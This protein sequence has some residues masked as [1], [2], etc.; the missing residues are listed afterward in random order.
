MP[1]PH[2]QSSPQED[3][4]AVMGRFHAWDAGRK[5]TAPSAPAE[6]MREL[7]YEEALAFS[8]ARRPA[9]HSVASAKIAVPA[10]LV[11]DIPAAPTDK[12]LE[13]MVSRASSGRSAP[14]EEF[15]AQ[16]KAQPSVR[17]TRKVPGRK[18][19]NAKQARAA[20]VSAQSAA[21]KSASG[22][23]VSRKSA[24]ASGDKAQGAGV[25]AARAAKLA[26]PAYATPGKAVR[27][28]KPRKGTVSM[29]TVS[30]VVNSRP[31]ATPFTAT[32]KIPAKQARQTKKEAGT[33]AARSSMTFRGALAACLVEAPHSRTAVQ[34]APAGK[35]PPA[36]AVSL[37]ASKATSREGHRGTA[38]QAAGKRAV[39]ATLA[40]KAVA[41]KP[42]ESI[43][44][45]ISVNLRLSQAEHDR[46]SRG[47]TE[48]DLSL[49]AFIRESTLR[50][51][52]S[53]QREKQA[54]LETG[55]G[56][57]SHLLTDDESYD[58]PI[59]EASGPSLLMRMKN[60]W[61]GR[62]LTAIA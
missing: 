35:K 43:A 61:L 28:S 26:A 1:P 58:R 53:R 4:S 22:A 34:P 17:S 46:M 5:T 36:R 30:A 60:F 56:T 8:N 48:A 55:F 10:T 54:L 19:A 33:S 52:V 15:P 50:F 38:K 24:R 14:S 42:V 44:R 20:A 37:R 59:V 2:L 39:S 41:R 18:R 29:E 40:G 45:T 32:R 31:G 27:A 49:A 47:A 23:L 62:R 51:Q 9:R 13:P 12:P 3:L 25:Q 6:G 16:L 7:S 11:G 57:P 21:A